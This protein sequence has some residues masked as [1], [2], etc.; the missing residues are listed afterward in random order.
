MKE[1]SITPQTTE[2]ALIGRQSIIPRSFWKI[3]IDT[4]TVFKAKAQME[5]CFGVTTIRGLSIIL[6]G[7][8]KIVIEAVPK[9]QTE[10][11]MIRSI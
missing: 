3:S 9:L 10:T 4:K 7:S 8:N 6:D 1:S 2:V 5:L 11:K